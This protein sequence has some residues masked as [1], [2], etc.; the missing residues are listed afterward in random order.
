MGEASGGDEM[1]KLIR[2]D[3]G[4]IVRGETDDELLANAEEHI[5]TDHP[6]LV[7]KVQREDLLAAAEQV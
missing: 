6:D 1:A 4:V 5:R 3:C 2:C 7:G